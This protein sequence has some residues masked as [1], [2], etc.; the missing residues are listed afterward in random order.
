M[1]HDRYSGGQVAHLDIV[2]IS[3]RM[4]R[5]GFPQHLCHKLGI[6]HRQV[7]TGA[8]YK[9]LEISIHT[10]AVQVHLID[11]CKLSQI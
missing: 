8:T 1:D 5:L 11:D 4:T 10:S 6:R 3:K 2:A 9:V 7:V